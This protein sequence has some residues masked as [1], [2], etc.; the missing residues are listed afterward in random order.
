MATT[1][2]SM[3]LCQSRPIPK[4]K[5]SWALVYIFS[6]LII[7]WFPLP[8]GFLAMIDPK[9][10]EE[11]TASICPTKRNSSTTFS[12]TKYSLK[13]LRRRQKHE[14]RIRTLLSWFEENKNI[15]EAAQIE[16]LRIYTMETCKSRLDCRLDEIAVTLNL[17]EL[18][19]YHPWLLFVRSELDKMRRQT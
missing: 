18:P 12:R 11:A 5:I 14:S 2:N 19:F 15:C 4:S 9:Y 6:L 3:L 13:R 1:Y 7:V 10:C 17:S 8:N 16:W